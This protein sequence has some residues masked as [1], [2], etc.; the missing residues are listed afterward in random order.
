MTSAVLF[1]DGLGEIAPLADLRASFDI[2][3]G[4]LTTRE[5]LER[6][7][8]LRIEAVFV[9][10]AL[11]DMYTSRAGNTPVNTL[12][13][14][15]EPVLLIN[16]RCALGHSSWLSLKPGESVV[17]Q[18]TGHVVA[19]CTPRAAALAA[20]IHGST[21]VDTTVHTLPFPALLSRPWHVRTFR[22]AAIDV[23]LRLL[24]SSRPVAHDVSTR[25]DLHTFGPH[26]LHI[27]ATAKVYPGVVLDRE[28]GP[29]FIDQHAVIRPGVTIIGPVYI[30]QHAH[31]LDRALIK[32]HT[33]I[34]PWCKVAGEIGGTIFQGFANKAHD[35]HLGDSWIGEWANLG[36]GTTN[37][38]L[39]NTY[40]EVTAR[41]TPGSRNER[42]GHQFLGCIIGDHVKTAIGTR[43][44]T[45]TV[46]HT[47]AMLAQSG[48]VSGC[49]PPFAWCTDGGQAGAPEKAQ[50]FRLDKFMDIA[51]TVM[52]RRKVE[53][54]AAYAARLAAL[55]ASAESARL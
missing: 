24:L 16:G 10:P 13:P 29:I 52:A 51:G 38:N 2:R 3:T 17:E 6:A 4:A 25:T 23:D 27:S 5:R 50:R 18:T 1:D 44:M 28:S 32:G 21:S 40:A 54:P 43:I 45:G 9:R 20:H 8:G 48:F 12:S 19:A 15:D 41:A 34:G 26:P 39:L 35:G 33:S 30:G 49:I 22:D 53:V 46:V 14:T 36:A 55:H 11:V 37:S 31:I 47:G 7:L 42:T